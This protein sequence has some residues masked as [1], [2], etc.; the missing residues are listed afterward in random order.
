MNTLCPWPTFHLNFNNLGEMQLLEFFGLLYYVQDKNSVKRY[1]WYEN[2]ILI[3]R[4]S[5]ENQK[6]IKRKLLY[7]LF[8]V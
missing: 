2:S 8:V 3:L 1:F 6:E 4:K 7:I 5:K